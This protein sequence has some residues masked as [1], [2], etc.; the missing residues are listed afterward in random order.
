MCTS[1]CIPEVESILFVTSCRCE[2]C[3]AR[4]VPPETAHGIL[5]D[6]GVLPLHPR[7]R[8]VLGL[9]LDQQRGNRRQDRTRY[10]NV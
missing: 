9:V 6:P 7:G 10:V 3:A 2:L 5:P 4:D 1:G 8:S